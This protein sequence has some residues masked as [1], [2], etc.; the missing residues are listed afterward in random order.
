MSVKSV[1]NVYFINVN[2]ISAISVCK[3]E[4]LISYVLKAKISTYNL[5]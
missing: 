1:D 4:F 3:Y 5:Y 2:M